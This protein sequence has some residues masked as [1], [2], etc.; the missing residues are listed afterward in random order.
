[1][2]FVTYLMASM[3]SDS[4]ITFGKSSPHASRR[5][6]KIAQSPATK[7]VSVGYVSIN[8][9]HHGWNTKH[10]INGEKLKLHT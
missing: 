8:L 1:M 6:R 4:K 7:V 9:D 3:E 2:L 10:N 5:P